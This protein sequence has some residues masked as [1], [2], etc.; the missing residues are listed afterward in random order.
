MEIKKPAYQQIID[1]AHD[2]AP[3]ECCGYLAGT[4]ETI[5]MAYPMENS[6]QSSVHYSFRP[7]EQFA[8]I[9]AIRKEQLEVLGVYHSHPE[10][11]ARPSEEDI[12]L[13]F[14]NSVSYVII[15][16][17]TEETMVKSFRIEDGEVREEELNIL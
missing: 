9:K 17:L 13:A 14:D 5:T 7:E 3:L 1:H 11:P 2:E 15:S 4:G 10:S 6:D 8:T 12:K 16:L